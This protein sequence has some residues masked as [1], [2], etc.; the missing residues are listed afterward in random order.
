MSLLPY[1]KPLTA[2][3]V[4]RAKSLLAATLASAS[5]DCAASVFRGCGGVIVSWYLTTSP[6][7]P[8]NVPV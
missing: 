5:S 7:V 4:T 6:R 3:A 8:R 1:V 2:S